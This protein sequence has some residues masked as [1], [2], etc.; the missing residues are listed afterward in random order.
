MSFSLV[1]LLCNC[2]LPETLKTS[3][4]PHDPNFQGCDSEK[5]RLRTAFSCWSSISM[6]QREVSISSLFLHSHYKG[7]LPPWELKRSKSRSLK[8]EWVDL[9]LICV[10]VEILTILCLEIWSFWRISPHASPFG[11]HE[12]IAPQNL[13]KFFILNVEAEGF[14]LLHPRFLLAWVCITNNKIFS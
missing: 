9:V 12:L 2:I 13:C 10:S 14:T 7:C 6:P 5:K 1:G 4:V 3:T 8:E 11:N